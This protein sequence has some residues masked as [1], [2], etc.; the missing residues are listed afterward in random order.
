I[1]SFLDDDKAPQSV[2]GLG[3]G[4]E[5]ALD[6]E[7]LLPRFDAPP[8]SVWPPSQ[9]LAFVREA[10]CLLAPGARLPPD[11]DRA[12]PGGEVE[13]RAGDAWVLLTA[14]SLVFT[15]DDR[16]RFAL[17][18]MAT[19]RTVAADLLPASTAFVLRRHPSGGRSRLWAIRPALAPLFDEEVGPPADEALRDEALQLLASATGRAV[20]LAARY[21]VVLT[22]RP[23]RLG[24]SAGQ[25]VYLGLLHGPEALD[26][27]FVEAPLR[28]ADRL[29]DAPL[30]KL[31]GERLRRAL[32]RYTTP[33]DLTVIG[34]A[35][36][37]AAFRPSTDAGRHLAA[38]L[39]GL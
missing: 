30:A 16:A 15:D 5:A 11:A 38:T 20:A 32:L 2:E 19:A 39:R 7:D 26:V 24:V 6:D 13:L 29:D 22:V 1:S 35:R 21:G 3:L 9:G 12:E 34:F 8:G 10:V 17:D 4:G 27:G 31:F 18:E 37:L 33:S 23:K 36:T 28:W 14:P 25:P